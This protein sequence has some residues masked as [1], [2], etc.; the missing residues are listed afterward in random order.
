MDDPTHENE[1]A[2]YERMIRTVL[3][4]GDIGGGSWNDDLTPAETA[5]G[6]IVSIRLNAKGDR[7]GEDYPVDDPH[8]LA[9]KLMEYHHRADV[10]ATL[11]ESNTVLGLYRERGIVYFDVSRLF[12]DKHQ[13]VIAGKTV[14]AKGEHEHSIYDVDAPEGQDLIWMEYYTPEGTLYDASVN[15]RIPPGDNE[16]WQNS[17]YNPNRRD[18]DGNPPAEAP[19]DSSPSTPPVMSAWRE[20]KSPAYKP[21]QKVRKKII[22]NGMIHG[23]VLKV[24]KH[25]DHKELLYNVLWENGPIKRSNELA[26]HLMK[27]EDFIFNPGDYRESAVDGVVDEQW[28]TVPHFDHR[29]KAKY[30]PGDIVATPMGPAHVINTA[31]TPLG[32]LYRVETII[33]RTMYDFLEQE[34]HG[35]GEPSGYFAKQRT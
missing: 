6:Y 11:A 15:D 24:D 12:H 2:P 25:P 7:L 35:Q 10:K 33:G 5:G 21:G 4:G 30:K 22:G 9:P 27:E 8:R 1:F 29:D 14:D 20:A 17:P 23:V 13:A 31:N 28:H 18:E 19:E 26:H 16:A 32:E 34:L 3:A